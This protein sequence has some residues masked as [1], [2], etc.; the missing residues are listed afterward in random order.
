MIRS[1]IFLTYPNIDEIVKQTPL[2]SFWK[3]CKVPMH[4]QIIAFLL[5]K[6]DGGG[7]IFESTKSSG[8]SNIVI[9]AKDDTTSTAFLNEIDVI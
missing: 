4:S 2:N 8:I 7:L 9:L 6:I 5:S 3:Y 1:L